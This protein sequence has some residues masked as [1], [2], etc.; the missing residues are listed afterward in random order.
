MLAKAKRELDRLIHAYSSIE[1]NRFVSDHGLNFAITAW[2]IAD[3]VWKVYSPHNN[4]NLQ[5]LDLKKL[6]DL[7]KMIRSNSEALAI[8]Y[9]IANGSKHMKLDKDSGYTPSVADTNAS[10]SSSMSTSD[11]FYVLK[12]ELPNGERKRAEEIFKDAVAYWEEF[13]AKYDIA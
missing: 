8:C 6:Y 2:H 10:I 7:Q 9:E 12:V 4:K 5:A 1:E 13:F 11:I 3:W